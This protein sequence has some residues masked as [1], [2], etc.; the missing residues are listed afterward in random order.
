MSPVRIYDIYAK[1]AFVKFHIFLFFSDLISRALV[2]V[3]P[4][5]LWYNSYFGIS[6]NRGNH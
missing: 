1:G 2:Y 5:L 3:L 4:L 6:Y